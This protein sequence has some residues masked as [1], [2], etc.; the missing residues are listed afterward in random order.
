MKKLIQD[1]SDGTISHLDIIDE[2]S[3][4]SEEISVSTYPDPD[5]IEHDKFVDKE[6][7]LEDKIDLSENYS[8]IFSAWLNECG[9]LVDGNLY[10]DLGDNRRISYKIS[11]INKRRRTI[12]L[13][14]VLK[15]GYAEIDEQAIARVRFKGISKKDYL[16]LSLFKELAVDAYLLEQEENRKMAFFTYFS[17]IEAIVRYKLHSIRPN[18]FTELY[19]ALEHL[20]LDDKLRIVAKDAFNTNDLKSIA[21]WGEFQGALRE[22]KKIRNLIAH[23]KLEKEVTQEDVNKC[24]ACYVTTYC[25]SIKGC[26][27]FKEIEKYLKEKS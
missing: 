2:I 16:K 4:Y 24:I 10:D 23:G 9:F 19:D 13:C 22:V 21:I 25:F 26:K 6:Y 12:E 20:S 7:Y 15:G 18:I 3:E 1:I 5:L 11:S 27:T 17:A 8:V 14:G